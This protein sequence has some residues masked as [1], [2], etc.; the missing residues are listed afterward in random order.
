MNSTQLRLC[1]KYVNRVYLQ[2]GLCLF[3][4]VFIIKSHVQLSVKM[5]YVWGE[6]CGMCVCV[7]ACMYVYVYIKINSKVPS[8]D[9][10]QL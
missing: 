3:E 10:Y 6:V 4:Y 7:C 5:N 8:R 2:A 9:L 1:Q